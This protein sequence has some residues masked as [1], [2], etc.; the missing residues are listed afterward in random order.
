LVEDNDDYRYYLKDQLKQQHKVIE[1]TNG[2]EG[3]K[4]ALFHHP[5][6]I[7]SDI[8]M[9]EMNGIDLCR[10][11]KADKRTRHI[12]VILLT[13][14]TGEENQLGGLMTGANDYISKSFNVNLLK[15]K[16]ENLLTST[17]ILKSTFSKQFQSPVAEVVDIPSA[18]E[19][20]LQRIRV[21][22]EENLSNPNLSVEELSK[23]AGMSRSSLY[24]KLLEITGQTPVEYIRSF[25]LDKA[26]ALLSVSNMNVTQIA[27]TVGFST[28]NYFAKSFKIK[29]NMLPSEFARMKKEGK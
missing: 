15:A 27:Y 6:L 20:L 5:Q 2:R 12:P 9:P 28:P 26:A 8:S 1:A 23:Q 17:R 25:K 18:D 7:V 24:G 29:Y 11:I 14:L 3:W 13:A 21:Y 4:Q 19:E 16:I 10:K 22:L